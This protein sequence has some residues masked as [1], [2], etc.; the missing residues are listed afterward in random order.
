MEVRSSPPDS[1][2][3]KTTTN[4]GVSW[5][6]RFA[7]RWSLVLRCLSSAG[8]GESTGRVTS[9]VV[10]AAFTGGAVAGSGG[11]PYRDGGRQV[12]WLVLVLVGTWLYPVV[13]E[14]MR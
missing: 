9:D 10:G 14:L 8:F 3:G 1:R 11:V 4:G 12:M 6:V 5:L 7:W 2:S 13:R